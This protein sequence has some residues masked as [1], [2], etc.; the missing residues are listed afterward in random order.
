MVDNT[1]GHVEGIGGVFFKA[2]DPAT[3]RE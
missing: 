3:L 1:A 2:G